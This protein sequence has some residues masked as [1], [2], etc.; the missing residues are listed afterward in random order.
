MNMWNNL[1]EDIRN[2]PSI[3]LFKKKLNDEITQ[4]PSYF[5]SGPRKM[6]IIIC[7]LL[8]NVSNLNDHL[9]RAHLSDSSQC[10]CGDAVEDSFHYFYVCPLYM[11]HRIIMFQDLRRYR[12]IL[13]LEILLQGSD[14]LSLDENLYILQTVY[15]YI[16]NTGR[17]TY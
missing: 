1:D 3:S 13:N 2:I 10:P 12:D 9:F 15:R 14:N 4:P 16:E 5:S 6:N 8:N 7:Q 17:F 11:R